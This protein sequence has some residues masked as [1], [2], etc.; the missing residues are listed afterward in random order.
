VNESRAYRI[1]IITG[2]GNFRVAPDSADFWGN[3]APATSDD[4]SGTPYY[5][6]E[7]TAPKGVRISTSDQSRAGDG[8]SAL[9]VGTIDPNSWQRIVAFGADGTT[10]DNVELAIY[11]TG[12]AETY[13]RL[14]GLTGIVTVRQQS[15]E[16]K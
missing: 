14:R 7:G 4:G 10:I 3:N 8:D 13:L 2:H 16:G 9:P 6:L 15:A 5:M 1:A 12:G 11:G